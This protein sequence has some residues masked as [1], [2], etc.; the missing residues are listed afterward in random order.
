MSLRI[1]CRPSTDTKSE[2]SRP[3]KWPSEKSSSNGALACLIRH[4]CTSTTHIPLPISSSNAWLACMA[5]NARELK[6]SML[7]A[8]TMLMT[9]KAKTPAKKKL[10]FAAKKKANTAIDWRQM[11]T[12]C[13]P[14]ISMIQVMMQPWAA[15]IKTRPTE[16]GPSEGSDPSETAQNCK[17]ASATSKA[18]MNRSIIKFS[19]QNKLYASSESKAHVAQAKVSLA[20]VPGKRQLTRHTTK[21][22]GTKPRKCRL[23]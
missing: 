22:T 19:L 21:Y 4:D 14:E 8:A 15:Q 18:T 23:L 12:K 2:K 10:G 17:P 3:T 5:A 13:T 9:V 20:G 16:T 11:Q 1:W 7:T 6:L